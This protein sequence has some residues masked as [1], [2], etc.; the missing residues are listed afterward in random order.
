[1]KPAPWENKSSN[2]LMSCIGTK[3]GANAE[4]GA[5]LPKHVSMQMILSWEARLVQPP[6]PF[7]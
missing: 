1:M 6:A 3:Y 5:W 7:L 2:Y 4:G